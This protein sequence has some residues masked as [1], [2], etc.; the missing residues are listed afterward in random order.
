MRHDFAGR[1]GL[2]I[3]DFNLIGPRQAVK[4]YG[5]TQGDNVEERENEEEAEEEPSADLDLRRDN[6]CRGSIS[7]SD[8][9]GAH[10]NADGDQ[11]GSEKCYDAIPV[12]AEGSDVVVAE[13]RD[14]EGER[15]EDDAEERGDYV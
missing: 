11:E 1:L 2:E 9:N 4:N 6:S 5:A 3:P 8:E 10:L 15:S 12:L 7:D 14:H 13:E